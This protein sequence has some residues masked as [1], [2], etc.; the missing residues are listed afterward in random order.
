MPE[1]VLH[2]RLGGRTENHLEIDLL[3]SG[4]ELVNVFFFFFFFR[5]ELNVLRLIS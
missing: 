2:H 4:H 5:L 1:N 3:F